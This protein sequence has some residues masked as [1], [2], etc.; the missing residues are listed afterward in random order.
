ML[1]SVFN[2]ALFDLFCK[3]RK[4]KRKQILKVT[5]LIIPV[6]YGHV[7]SQQFFVIETNSKKFLAAQGSVITTVANYTR[8]GS[9]PLP[10]AWCKD[11]LF[12]TITIYHIK[13]QH[14]HFGNLLN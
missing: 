7:M 9:K 3:E 8:P 10:E 11:L 14:H 13:K 4:G 6:E 2:I 12:G 1:N 5:L